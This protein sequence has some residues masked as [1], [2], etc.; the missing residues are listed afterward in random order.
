MLI[1]IC[2]G[3]SNTE[4][5]HFSVSLVQLR[6]AQQIRSYVTNKACFLPVINVGRRA[7]VFRQQ[8]EHVSLSRGGTSP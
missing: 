5:N 3:F 4:Q 7:V 6:Q 1:E 2:L 8:K